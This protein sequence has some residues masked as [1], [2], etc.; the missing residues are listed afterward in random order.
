MRHLRP[1]LAVIISLLLAVCRL[2]G[3]E[4]VEGPESGVAKPISAS[5]AVPV[6]FNQQ[7]RPIFEKRCYECHGPQKQK[8]G[9]R[10]D[11][12]SSALRGGDSGKPALLAGKSADS[13]LIQKISSRDPD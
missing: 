12:K 6:D 9:L 10:L 2:S 3:V 11:Q 4:A 7:V 1:I 8:S 5:N 13:L